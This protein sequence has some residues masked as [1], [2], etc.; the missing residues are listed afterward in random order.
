[1]GW[2]GATGGVG[3]MGWVG[4]S[5]APFAVTP[6]CPD[7]QEAQTVEACQN[8]DGALRYCI[9]FN[10]QMPIWMYWV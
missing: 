9:V 6:F 2:A 8:S 5:V 4:Y 7:P 3:Y 1:M 10:Q